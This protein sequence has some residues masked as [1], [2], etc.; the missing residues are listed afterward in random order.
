[1]RHD[2]FNSDQNTVSAWSQSLNDCWC[3]V[4]TVLFFLSF[5]LCFCIARLPSIGCCITVWEEIAWFWFLQLGYCRSQCI[6]EC[7]SVTLN[8]VIFVSTNVVNR[9]LLHIISMIVVLPG[10][11]PLLVR[12]DVSNW[13]DTR[14]AECGKSRSLLALLCFDCS[15][16]SFLPSLLPSLLPSFFPSLLLMRDR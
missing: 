16:R 11:S 1:M 4:L 12:G 7:S 15:F 9:P 5:F 3:S 6:C 8:T 10:H 2:E 14:S 13:V